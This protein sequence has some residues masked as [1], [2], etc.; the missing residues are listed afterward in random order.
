MPPI[1]LVIADDH[2]MFRD[3]FKQFMRKRA[4]NQVTVVGEASDGFE[5]LD[6]VNDSK[7]DVV[8]TDV[9]MP[10][11]N[12]ILACRKIRERHNAVS[13]LA[14]SSFDEDSLIYDISTPVPVGTC[15]RTPVRKTY[16]AHWKPSRWASTITPA[17]PHHRS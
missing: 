17:S 8:I 10:R 7:P 2:E 14:M 5:L 4:K 11:M 9:K 6:L 12:G 13:V 16:S 3:G 1:R 15:S